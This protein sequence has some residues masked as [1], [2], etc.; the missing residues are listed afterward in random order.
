M[1]TI[2]LKCHPEGEIPTTPRFVG[3]YRRRDIDKRSRPHRRADAT[4]HR[5]TRVADRVQAHPG[6]YTDPPCLPPPFDAVRDATLLAGRKHR[7]R[8]I[9]VDRRRRQIL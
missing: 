7:R 1:S 6:T 9:Y 4:T 5:H 2:D 3:T 8:Q